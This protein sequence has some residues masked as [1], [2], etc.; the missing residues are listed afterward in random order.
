MMV[1]VGEGRCW[2][3]VFCILGGAGDR[4]R[5]G[6]GRLFLTERR[7]RMRTLRKAEARRRM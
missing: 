6:S 5:S 3:V 2:V 1:E 4:G 7:G